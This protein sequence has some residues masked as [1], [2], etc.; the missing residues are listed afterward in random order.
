M[1][2]PNKLTLFRVILVP[3][4]V[5]ALY[6]NLYVAIA[7]F[8]VASLTDQL[9]GHIARKYNMV[10]TFGKLMDPLADKI[11]TLSAFVCFVGLD[12]E[13]VPA[14]L[15]VIIIARELMVT[16]IRL[17]ALSENKVIAAG[18][19][20]KLKTV[21]QIAAIIMLMLDKIVPLE[22]AGVKLTMVIMAA[23]LVLTVYSG[24]DY[25]VKNRELLTLK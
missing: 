1:N 25:I 6:S 11:L 10:T 3:F 15:T 16:G 24:V 7:I 19:W 23:V 17:I 20:G 18:S 5:W 9:D 22:I 21:S 12:Y 8:V 4:F 2:L 14:W 13:F